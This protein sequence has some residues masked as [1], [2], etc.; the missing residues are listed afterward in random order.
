MAEIR[1]V[2]LTQLKPAPYNPRRIDPAA[3][4]G[5]EKSI[6]RYGLVEPVIWNQRSGFV[7]G[8]HQR[9]KVLR[10]Q[11]V[12]ETAVVVVDLDET[13]EKA[14]NVAL[15]SPHISGEFSYKLSDLLA[16][17]EAADTTLFAELRLDQLLAEAEAKQ[18]DFLTKDLDEAPEP[19]AEP[20]TKPGDVWVLGRHR[21]IC[22]DSAN[23]PTLSTLLHDERVDM[24]LTDP[25]YG[26]DLDTKNEFLNAGGRGN[27]VQRPIQNDNFEMGDYRAWFASWMK[28]IPWA[29]YAT[30]Y[31]FMSNREIHNVRNACDDLGLKFG[32]ILAWVKNQQIL[33]RADY[34]NKHELILYGWPKRHRFYAKDHPSTVLEFDK[35][36]LSDL[37]PTMKPVALLERLLQ[38]GSPDAAVILDLFGGSGST[39]IACEASQRRA[40]LVEID[41]AY[42]DVICAR[43]ATLTGQTPVLEV[44][45]GHTP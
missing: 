36:R 40:R 19:P 24:L 16:E 18:R 2:P 28:G 20:V 33:G 11:K 9:L 44:P 34:S 35:P 7:V 14:L 26:V 41:P 45:D 21:L 30:Y 12:K 43:W 42:C 15:N 4:A 1:T 3:M 5:L 13:D 32:S 25:P 29:S 38:D 22:G 10:N 23:G 37:H 6:A 39:L 17:I 8:G 27:H 31:V